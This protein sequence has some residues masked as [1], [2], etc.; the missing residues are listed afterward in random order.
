MAL[1]DALSVSAKALG[2]GADIYFSTDRT[3]YSATQVAET[4]TMKDSKAADISFDWGN[5]A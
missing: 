1:T 4:K 3:K 5:A 2:I